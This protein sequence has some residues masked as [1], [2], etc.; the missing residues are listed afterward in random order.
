VFG[1]FNYVAALVQG[2]FSPLLNFHQHRVATGTVI[3]LPVYHAIVATGRQ[4]FFLRDFLRDHHGVLSNCTGSFWP[5]ISRY[6]GRI[7]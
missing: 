4:D 7:P 2:V 3:Q 6:T 1:L 5:S